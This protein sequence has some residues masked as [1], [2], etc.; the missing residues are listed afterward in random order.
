MKIG[1]IGPGDIAR[2]AYLPVLAALPDLELHPHTRT[3]STL[4]RVLEHL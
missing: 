3:R 1:V 2:K 4:D